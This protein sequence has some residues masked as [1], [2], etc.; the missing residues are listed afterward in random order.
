MSVFWKRYGVADSVE[1]PLI[2]R[3]VVDFAVAADYTPVQSDVRIHIDAASASYATNVQLATGSHGWA[4]PLLASELSGKRITIAVI[5]AATKAV[6]D[7]FII[8]E[9]YGSPLAQHPFDLSVNTVAVAT[10]S[11]AGY[12]N[13]VNAVWATPSRT[14]TN[15]DDSVVSASATSKIAAAVWATPSTGQARTDL[16]NHIW[17]TGS[18]TLTSFGTLQGDIVNNVWATGSRTLTSLGTGVIGDETFKT[19]G[20]F[21]ITSN[22]WATASRALSQTSYD[23]LV[24]QIW[25][26]GSRTLTSLGTDIISAAALSAAGANKVADHVWRRTYA[27]I[28]ASANGD[29][30]TNR[31]GLGAQAKLVNLVTASGATLNVYHEDDTTV[32]LAQTIATD[33]SASPIISLDTV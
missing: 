16:V 32:F 29:T 13:L 28:R 18:R 4:L 12:T 15:L 8:V 10:I 25:A 6:E 33:S 1:Y 23:Q 2:K 30:V 9:T 7:Q 24:N 26:T 14:L 5:D 11:S 21:A 22:V 27:N 31:S 20:I 17:A 19:S 3:A